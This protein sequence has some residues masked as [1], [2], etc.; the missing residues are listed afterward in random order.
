[1]AERCRFDV[2]DGHKRAYRSH[3]VATIDYCRE[4][5]ACKVGELCPPRKDAK[6]CLSRENDG[7][8]ADGANGLVRRYANE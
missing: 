4:K 3:D 1:M 8:R 5:D 6:R 2:T 7:L